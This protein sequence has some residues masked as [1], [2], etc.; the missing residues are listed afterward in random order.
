MVIKLQYKIDVYAQQTNIILTF[1]VSIAEP[2][3]FNSV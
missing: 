2:E 3:S 1:D